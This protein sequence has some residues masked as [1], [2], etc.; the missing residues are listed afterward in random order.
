MLMELTCF[1]L[2]GRDDDLTRLPGHR[3]RRVSLRREGWVGRIH[4]IDGTPT[5]VVFVLGRDEQTVLD[6]IGLST[7]AEGEHRWMDVSSRPV[8]TVLQQPFLAQAT[9]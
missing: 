2:A 9:R 3:I 6:W 7:L 1:D 8:G 4:F 5:E